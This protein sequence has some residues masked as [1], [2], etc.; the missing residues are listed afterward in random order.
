M[1]ARIAGVRA[2]PSSPHWDGGR[3][4]FA[5][6]GSMTLVPGDCV[7]VEPASGDASADEPW[8]GEVVVADEVEHPGGTVQ[9]RADEGTCRVSGD[10]HRAAPPRYSRCTPR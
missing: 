2:A 9:R 7:I 10:G 8:V 3:L 6:A 4:R 1:T 5:D